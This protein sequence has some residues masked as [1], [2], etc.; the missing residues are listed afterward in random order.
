LTLARA[1]EKKAAPENA[2]KFREETSKKAAGRGAAAVGNLRA[3]RPDAQAFF[4]AAHNFVFMPR[5]SQA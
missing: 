5:V 4:G 1:D 2:A 3:I